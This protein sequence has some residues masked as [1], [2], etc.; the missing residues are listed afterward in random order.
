MRRQKCAYR[1]EKVKYN[2]CVPTEAPEHLSASVRALLRFDQLRVIDIDVD[3]KV[4]VE[5]G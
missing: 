5:E 3:M 4:E 1:K 2:L